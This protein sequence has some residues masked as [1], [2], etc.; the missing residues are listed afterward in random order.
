MIQ[1]KSIPVFLAFQ[2]VEDAFDS[3]TCSVNTPHTIFVAPAFRYTS[4]R[5]GVYQATRRASRS[6]EVTTRKQI[7]LKEKTM[8][9]IQSKWFAAAAVALLAAGIAP[10]AATATNAW[11]GGG[12]YDGYDGARA[13]DRDGAATAHVHRRNWT[14]WRGVRLAPSGVGD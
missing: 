2:I 12:W 13:S 7:E 9:N 5:N 1:G 4:R 3:Y 11:F 10:A 8:M 6:H 14:G